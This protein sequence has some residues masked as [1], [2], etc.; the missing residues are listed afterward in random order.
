M[1]SYPHALTMND[2]LVTEPIRQSHDA[3]ASRAAVI[4]AYVV[5]HIGCTPRQMTSLSTMNYSVNIV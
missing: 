4:S 2:S 5:L 3:I 1:L